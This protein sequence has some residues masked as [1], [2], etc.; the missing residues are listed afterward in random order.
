[1][2][3]E[4]FPKTREV[5]FRGILKTTIPGKINNYLLCEELSRGSF[6]IIYST[7]NTYPTF[8]YY[9]CKV[10]PKAL[11]VY[12]APIKK[13]VEDEIHITK[14]FNHHQIIS[15]VEHFEDDN[16]IYIIMPL[17]KYGNLKE[18]LENHELIG[19]APLIR[20]IFYQVLKVVQIIHQNYVCH[21]D[22]KAENILVGNDFT[23]IISDFGC[24]LTVDENYTI[25]YARGTPIYMS[26]ECIEN[27]PHDGR[28]SDV[29]CC[30]VLLYR[31][32][33]GQNP[34]EERTTF[35]KL[36]ETIQNGEFEIPNTIDPEASNMIR[37][38]MTVDFR[39]RITIAEALEDKWF[40]KKYD[41]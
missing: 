13:F 1:M 15:I 6:S 37:K 41:E 32:F 24:S 17:F 2:F 19:Y 25:P 18:Y 36:K 35:Q 26:P 30:G 23:I 8:K 12:D 7:F 21:C 10:V 27:K 16:N 33:T 40:E 22:I 11:T 20:Y 34:F 39:R 29:W 3:D 38:L 5:E 31:M 9:A 4:L 14:L 28:A